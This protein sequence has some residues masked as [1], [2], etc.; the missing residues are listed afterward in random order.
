MDFLGV[1]DG[2]EIIMLIFYAKNTQW[3]RTFSAPNPLW[4]KALYANTHFFK[5]EEEFCTMMW[6]DDAFIGFFI[7]KENK[8]F[9]SET[10]VFFWLF[11]C[12][13]INVGYCLFTP[14][15]KIWHTP[16]SL[17]VLASLLNLSPLW[18]SIPYLYLVVN[19]IVPKN[20]RPQVVHPSGSK[21][22]KKTRGRLYIYL[23]E[24]NHWL[25]FTK[26]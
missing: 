7:Y 23:S 16:L 21:N 24:W 3:L 25:L 8:C 15:N 22:F 5:K 4:C 14:R 17:I 13:F 2:E 10:L 26:L 11:I 19:K 18:Q 20:V 1:W 6:T 9:A 12:S